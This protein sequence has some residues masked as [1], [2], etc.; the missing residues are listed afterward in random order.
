MQVTAELSLYPLTPDY[1]G[2]IIAFIKYLKD[3][4][5]LSVCTHSMSTYVKGESTAVFRAINDALIEV[6]DKGLTA[7][8]VIKII[9]RNLPVEKGFLEF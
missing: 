9:N 5:S 7:S 1:E 6:S 4:P 2:P 3:Q 8:L